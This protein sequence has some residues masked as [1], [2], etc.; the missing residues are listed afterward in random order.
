MKPRRKLKKAGSIPQLVLEEIIG[1]SVKN[2]NG[3]ASSFGTSRCVYTA[4]C[5]AVVYNVELGTQQSH[6]MLPQTPPKPLS[7][8]AI[9]L[10]GRYVAAGEIGKQASVIVWDC[11]LLS[12]ISVLKGHQHGVVSIAF[13]P[14]GKHLVSAGSTS[15]GYICLWNWQSGTLVSKLIASSPSSAILSVSFSSN[16]KFVVIA[17]NNHLK[18]CSIRPNARPNSRSGTGSLIFGKPVNVTHQKGSSF[19]SLACPLWA[20][21]NSAKL[22]DGFSP[23]FALSDKGVLCQLSAG[24]KVQKSV[25]LKVEKA[26]SLSASNNMIACACNCGIVQLFTIDTL[27]YVGE[28]HYS[29]DKKSQDGI[30][31]LGHDRM[32]QPDTRC[33]SPFPDAVACQFVTPEKLVV[34]YGDHSLYVW[35]VHDTCKPTRCCVLVSHSAC[36][37]DIKSLP[38]EN[39]HNPSSGC[40]ARG[41]SGGV[42][43]ATCSGDGTIRIWDFTFQSILSGQF[44][45]DSPSLAC[46]TI[47][48]T[49]LVSSGIF[50]REAVEVDVNKQGFRSMTVSED[51]KYLAAGNLVGSLLIYNLHTSTCVCVQDAHGAE[52]LSLSFSSPYQ[53][54]RMSNKILK[55]NYLLASGCRDGVIHLYDVE[56]DF[57]VIGS[58]DDHSTAVTIVQLGP[59]GCRIISGGADGTIIFHDVDVTHTGCQL[60]RHHHQR[61][62]AGALYDMFIDPMVEF[63]VTVGQGANICTYDLSS[64]ELV[65]ILKLTEGFSNPIK[66]TMDPSGS[67][68][69]CSYSNRTVCMYDYLTGELV[70]KVMGHS[71]VVTGIIFLPDCRHIVS[72]SGDSCIFLWK[73]P[74]T[75]SERM[76]QRMKESS[77]PLSPLDVPEKLTVGAFLIREDDDANQESV[78]SLEDD[79]CF[80]KS[81][82]F[83]AKGYQESSA[84]RFS[85]SRLPKWAQKEVVGTIPSVSETILP[86]YTDVHSTPLAIHDRVKVSPHHEVETSPDLVAGDFKRILNSISSCDTGSSQG[87]INPEIEISAISFSKMRWR[88]IHTVCLDQLT[89]EVRHL[90]SSNMLLSSI[91]LA[92][93]TSD[94]SDEKQVTGNSNGLN[95]VKE[96][97][98]FSS[99]VCKDQHCF[100]ANNTVERL[101]P[102]G[103]GNKMPAAFE[104][105]NQ[106]DS[107]FERHFNNLSTI[108]KVEKQSSVM[109]K[110]SSLFTVRRNNFKGCKT[111]S[112]SSNEVSIQNPVPC[113]LLED[114]SSD[115]IVG[116]AHQALSELKHDLKTKAADLQSSDLSSSLLEPLNHTINK[117]LNQLDVTEYDP[118]TLDRQEVIAQL[119]EALFGL[120][121]ATETV[122]NLFSKLESLLPKE[123]HA[124]SPEANVYHDAARVL[125]S[126]AEKIH[127]VSNL[128]CLVSNQHSL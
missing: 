93:G 42:P 87:Y 12:L 61:A 59:S 127:A 94:P 17:G 67:Y 22:A 16:A 120:N 97:A 24:F 54:R 96:K 80:S 1:L 111:L 128:V 92:Q 64:G 48:T 18:L 84:F 2:S 14:D 108:R 110:S 69:L 77:S 47:N 28:L 114:L 4:G 125:P 40:A 74:D 19:L 33:P 32:T 36:I 5:V 81:K 119:K 3:L 95:D 105:E 60:L 11:E 100:T 46:E 75:I 106:P 63:A 88:T 86:Q 38:C 122:H 29:L 124:A 101:T 121:A 79:R 82:Q 76:M 10:D 55:R 37:W 31:I 13:S 20:T 49:L 65:H 89:P 118:N 126:I 91:N 116:Q 104:I 26:F 8:V 27:T 115:S 107:F 78:L 103:D 98:L 23:I 85:I 57:A 117:D 9:S 112:S 72:V 44:S 34:I 99:T 90:N 53:E 39:N 113:M 62:C 102:C 56:R 7:C 21:G 41:C 83:F 43:F 71:E 15:D 35:D 68:L 52:I 123:D 51:G 6:L 66:V 50:E 73:V 58:I 70:A 25:N 45:T 30:D 109:K